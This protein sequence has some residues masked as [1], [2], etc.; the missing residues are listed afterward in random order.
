MTGR[1]TIMVTGAVPA[2]D[3]LADKVALDRNGFVLTDRD[4][5]AA[6]QTAASFGGRRGVDRGVLSP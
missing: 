2:T 1:H 3:W 6:A 4:L 5:P